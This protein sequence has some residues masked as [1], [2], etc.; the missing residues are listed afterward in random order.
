M[1]YK[2][3]NC[4]KSFFSSHYTQELCVQCQKKLEYKPL[5]IKPRLH[6][7]FL[8]YIYNINRKLYYKLEEQTR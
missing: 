6:K 3:C 4:G 2:I 8:D 1:P 5:K 7:T